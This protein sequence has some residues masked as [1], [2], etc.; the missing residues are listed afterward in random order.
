MQSA[1]AG[2]IF[3]ATD[4]A[5]AGDTSRYAVFPT[6]L[7]FNPDFLGSHDLPKSDV[8]DQ[9]AETRRYNLPAATSRRM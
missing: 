8:A 2:A 1:P 6:T 7:I 9:V 4:G 3:A 5:P